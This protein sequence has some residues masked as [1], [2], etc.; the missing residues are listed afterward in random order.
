MEKSLPRLELR[1]PELCLE[2]R[3]A[4]GSGQVEIPG[5]ITMLL[6]SLKRTLGV[7]LPSLKF[8]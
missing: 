8:T 4:Y 6:G 2:F 1:F 5:N 3:S 7:I